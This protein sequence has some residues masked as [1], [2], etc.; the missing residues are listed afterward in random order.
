MVLISRLMQR[1]LDPYESI[2]AGFERYYI[3]PSKTD[4]ID[5]FP[6]SSWTSQIYQ[7][8]IMKHL[9]ESYHQS[10]KIP[11]PLHSTI[12]LLEINLIMNRSLHQP[13]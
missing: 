9:I 3:L 6:R 5:Q 13:P 8:E 11:R 2:H 10:F 12:V 1:N 4:P 7:A